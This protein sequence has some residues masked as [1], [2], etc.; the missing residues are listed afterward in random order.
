MTG[1]G[2]CLHGNSFPSATAAQ[3]SNPTVLVRW[4]LEVKREIG[5]IHAKNQAKNTPWIMQD[6]GK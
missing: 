4:G 5:M 6:E 3:Q 1:G 2:G